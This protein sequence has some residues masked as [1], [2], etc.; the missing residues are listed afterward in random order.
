VT[1]ISECCSLSVSQAV[2]D[3]LSDCT[4]LVL[5]TDTAAKLGSRWQFGRVRGTVCELGLRRKRYGLE[6]RSCRTSTAKHAS[7]RI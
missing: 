7:L 6:D 1:K 2:R 3:M 5:G 4:V